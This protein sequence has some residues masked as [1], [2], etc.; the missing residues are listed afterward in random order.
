MACFCIYLRLSPLAVTGP[1]GPVHNLSLRTSRGSLR[2]WVKWWQSFEKNAPPLI[3]HDL[4]NFA[5]SHHGK[6]SCRHVSKNTTLVTRRTPVC[7]L[8]IVRSVVIPH[9]ALLIDAAS[10]WLLP[11]RVCVCVHMARPGSV[12]R[13]ETV[14]P[15]LLYSERLWPAERPAL[16]LSSP[17]PPASGQIQ[18]T[19]GSLVTPK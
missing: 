17:P 10:C 4:I 7:C 8:P 19:S 14:Y 11:G 16:H 3:Q 13:D 12:P 9:S 6:W 18:D 1:I 5:Y 2:E 15:S